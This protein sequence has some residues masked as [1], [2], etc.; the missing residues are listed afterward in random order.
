MSM[1]ITL[2]GLGHEA[3]EILALV[4]VIDVGAHVLVIATVIVDDEGPGPSLVIGNVANA[5]VQGIESVPGPKTARR[6]GGLAPRIVQEE[7]GAVTGLDEIEGMVGTM[8]ESRKNL[9]TKGM[10]IMGV[11]IMATTT[12]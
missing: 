1:S 12:T 2:A 11:T 6:A 7:T 3:G 8:S 4:I 5:A 10:G 9:R